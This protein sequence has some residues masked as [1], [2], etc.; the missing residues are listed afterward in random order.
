[1]NFNKS[2]PFIH[3]GIFFAYLNFKGRDFLMT[4]LKFSFCNILFLNNF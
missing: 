2:A 3:F 1:M 4:L